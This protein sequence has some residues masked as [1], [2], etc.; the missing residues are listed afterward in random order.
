MPFITPDRRIRMSNN[1]ISA[2]DLQPGDRCYFYYKRLVDTWKAEPRWTTAHNLYR[3][4]RSSIHNVQNPDDAAAY[5]LAWQCFFHFYVLPYEE[6][7]REE[8]GDI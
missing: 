6:L 4:V 3:Q 1:A 8:N 2:G 5:E 7:K